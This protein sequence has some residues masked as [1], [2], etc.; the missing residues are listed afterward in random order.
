VSVQRLV[1]ITLTEPVSM[2]VLAAALGTVVPGNGWPSEVRLS[3]TTHDELV[4][5]VRALA[6]SLYRVPTPADHAPPFEPL[7]VFYSGQ[8]LRVRSDFHTPRGVVRVMASGN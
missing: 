2:S 5:S 7:S 1:D 3:P 4:A 8:A 6:G